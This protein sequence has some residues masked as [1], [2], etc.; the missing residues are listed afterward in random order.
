MAQSTKAQ[1]RQ[2][3]IER[4]QEA[5]KKIEDLAPLAS[6]CYFDVE[7][8]MVVIEFSLGTEYRIPPHLV[9]GLES[10]TDAQLANIEIFPSG[11]ALRWPDLDVDLSIPLILEGLLGNKA[12][13][14]EI[15]AKGGR[16]KSDAKKAAA[17]ANGA[18]G[19]RPKKEEKAIA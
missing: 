10:A 4:A 2:A 5:F 9:Q 13:M 16:V 1:R 7:N 15:G 12:W 18:K 19:G 17:R 6:R 14:A 8:R 3:Q 11:S